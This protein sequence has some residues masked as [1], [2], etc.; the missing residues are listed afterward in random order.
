MRKAHARQKRRRRRRAASGAAL[1]SAVLPS[2]PP[3]SPPDSTDHENTTPYATGRRERGRERERGGTRGQRQGRGRGR[4]RTRARYERGALR[5]S[6]PNKL[7]SF[8]LFSTQRPLRRCH[9]RPTK[10]GRSTEMFMRAA[11]RLEGMCV[12]REPPPLAAVGV[13]ATSERVSRTGMAR[14]LWRV[15]RPLPTHRRSRPSLIEWPCNHPLP[16]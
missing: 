8:Q 16:L 9:D 13:R 6:W 14:T 11:G 3:P 2:R 15:A 12:A 1:P 5:R 10:R 4:E 7:S